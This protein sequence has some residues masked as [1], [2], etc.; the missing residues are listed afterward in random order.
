MIKPNKQYEDVI[1]IFCLV[2]LFFTFKCMAAVG[3]YCNGGV[4]CNVVMV[5]GG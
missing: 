5:G 4:H 3:C 2:F 1:F